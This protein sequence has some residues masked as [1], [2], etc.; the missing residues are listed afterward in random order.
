MNINIKLG[1]QVEN[2]QWVNDSECQW[3]L[4]VEQVVKGNVIPVIGSRLTQCKGENIS[5]ILVRNLSANCNMMSPAR[6]FSYLIPRFQVEYENESIYNVVSRILSDDDN[7]ELTKPTELLRELLSLKYFPFVIYTSYDQ[8]VERCMREIHGERLRVM[9][10]DNNAETNDDISPMD[11]LKTPTLYYIMGRANVEGRR[12]VLSDKDMLDFARSWLAET[13]STNRAKPARLSNALANRFLLVLGC[14][15]TDWL[16]RFLWFALKDSKI[17]QRLVNGQKIGLLTTDAETHNEELIDFLTRSNTLTQNVDLKEFVQ[18][19]MKRVSEKETLLASSDSQMKFA[20]PQTNTD[21]FISYSRADKDLAERLYDVLTDKG[22]NV[23]YDKQNL[24]LGA[25]FMKDIRLAVRTTKIFV[26]LLTRSIKEQAH[27]EHVYREEW[28][29]AV[30]RKRRLGNVTYIC[31]LC[32]DDISIE[33]KE[34]DL[35]DEFKAHNVRTV[36]SRPTEMELM[37]FAEEVMAEVEKLKN[38]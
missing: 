35:P 38:L 23:W 4:L 10:F 32:T 18:E 14:D 29:Y 30:E 33:D 16:F 13:D 8:T 28:G 15:Y 20:D 9:S 21:V 17:K 34:A 3:K 25:E 2:V 11:D 26:P 36:S 19:L 12:Y 22:L 31:P 27:E 24:G 37:T 7:A 6:N 5:D 1:K